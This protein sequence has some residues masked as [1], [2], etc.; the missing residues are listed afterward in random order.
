MRVGSVSVTQQILLRAA[1]HVAILGD[2]S[3]SPNTSGSKLCF[4]W[5]LILRDP[6][7]EVVVSAAQHVVNPPNRQTPM[8]YGKEKSSKKIEWQSRRARRSLDFLRWVPLLLQGSTADNACRYTHTQTQTAWMDGWMDRWI[9]GSI[10]GRDPFRWPSCDGD[11][12]HNASR[13]RKVLRRRPGERGAISCSSHAGYTRWYS[14]RSCYISCSC[15]VTV[16][17][18]LL[19]SVDRPIRDTYIVLSSKA[20]NY[21]IYTV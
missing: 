7:I 21:A 19:Y 6:G 11:K 4:E 3:F 1:L 12:Y 10:D 9:D 5:N 16:K 13:E 14:Q 18:M 2:L 15:S 17:K 8:A 20:I